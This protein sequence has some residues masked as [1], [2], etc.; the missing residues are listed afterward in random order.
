MVAISANDVENYPE[1]S[2]AKMKEKKYP[3]P[4]LYDESQTVAKNFGAV[5]TPDFF[6]YDREL[7]LA[8]RGR[9]DDSW[10]DAS[11]VRTQEL[12]AA[13]EAL[14]AGK[15]PPSEQKPS[16]GCNIKWLKH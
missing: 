7:R 10:K 11:A 15:A 14:L 3:F 13:I 1:D 9:L 12:R 4:Y 2:F 8:Y 6:L 16:M 5:C